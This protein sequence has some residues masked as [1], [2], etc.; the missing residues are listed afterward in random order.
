MDN[1]TNSCTNYMYNFDN[2]EEYVE[3]YLR[4]HLSM[5]SKVTLKQ[6]LFDGEGLYTVKWQQH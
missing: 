2:G 1:P 4:T 6:L 3:L 5:I